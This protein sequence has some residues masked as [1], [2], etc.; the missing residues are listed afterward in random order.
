N[1]HNIV[2][3]ATDSGGLP[4]T[5]NVTLQETDV[6]EAPTSNEPDGGYVFEYAENSD[7]GTLL[8]TVSASDVDEGDTLTYTITTN[9]E[10]DGLPL[11]RIDENS[12]EIYLTDKGVDVFTNNFEADP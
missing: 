7:T 8:G 11:Y 12:G 10:V 1:L 6:N 2:V 3:T 5:I 9:V 4:A